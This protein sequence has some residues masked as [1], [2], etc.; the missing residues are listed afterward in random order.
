MQYVSNV[1]KIFFTALIV[2]IGS[3]FINRNSTS[4]P[5]PNPTITSSGPS[6]TQGS[7]TVDP[8]SQASPASSKE[9]YEIG[10]S[11]YIQGNYLGAIKDYDQA[12]ELESNISEKA[13]TFFSR[14]QA[15]H[16]NKTFQKAIEDYDQAIKLKK[17]DC[18]CTYYE[19]YWWRGNAYHH[20]GKIDAAYADYKTVADSPTQFAQLAQDELKKLRR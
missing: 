17:D 13:T 16:R 11:K 20:L 8:S 7:N 12:I 2:G 6:T 5:N 19:A 14:G 9:F 4:S 3:T 1:L 18:R 15:Y 10:K